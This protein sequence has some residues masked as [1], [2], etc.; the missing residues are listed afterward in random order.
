VCAT[1][2]GQVAVEPFRDAVPIPP[3]V[4]SQVP[5]GQLVTV[6]L[7]AG[8]VTEQVPPPQSTMHDADCM[9]W[10]LQP[11][12]PLQSTSTVEP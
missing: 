2:Y 4:T 5:S 8:Q 12:E 3:Q 1:N 6:Q 11:G 7:L 9:H 10:T